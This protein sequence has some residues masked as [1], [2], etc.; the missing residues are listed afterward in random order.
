MCIILLAVCS[1]S[2]N[3]DSLSRYTLRVLC[4]FSAL[5]RSVGS[6]QIS[7]IIS[8]SS[9]SRITKIMIMA[10]PNGRRKENPTADRFKCLWTM[11]SLWML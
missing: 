3:T 2:D 7:I 6:L 4:L 10:T 5:S 9:S 8:S 1:A 11:I